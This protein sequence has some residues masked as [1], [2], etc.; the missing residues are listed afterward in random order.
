[1][2]PEFAEFLETTPEIDRTGYVFNPMPRRRGNGRLKLDAVSKV[3]CRIG[4]AAGVKVA[5]K[6][7]KV[8]FASAHDLR[9]S[10][11]FRW[12][13]RVMPPALMLLMRHESIQTTQAY[14]VERNAE[15]AADA[16]WDAFANI[17]S[18]AENPPV[19][20]MQETPENQGF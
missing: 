3:I 11:G 13:M 18:V 10:F 4:K 6:R 20:K 1:M 19:P 14:Y 8:K 16:I 17:G 7:G 12:A 2:T 15:A 5:E 9:R